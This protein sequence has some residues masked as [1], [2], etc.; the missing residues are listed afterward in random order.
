MKQQLHLIC[1]HTDD[2]ELR[3]L[4]VSVACF[5]LF[6]FE[7]CSPFVSVNVYVHPRP[8]SKLFLLVAQVDELSS[9][10]Y[11][12]E[13]EK[14]SVEFIGEMEKLGSRPAVRCTGSTSHQG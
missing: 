3:E 12:P 8:T 13:E 1:L 11:F 5:P 10:S 6:Y 14:E 4:M 2:K 7:A 9:R